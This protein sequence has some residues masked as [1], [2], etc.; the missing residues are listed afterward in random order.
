MLALKFFKRKKEYYIARLK[1][2]PHFDEKSTFL[3]MI[4]ALKPQVEAV[5]EEIANSGNDPYE[6]SKHIIRDN[7]YAAL[8]NHIKKRDE[9]EA[10]AMNKML[11]MLANRLKATVSKSELYNK[12]KEMNEVYMEMQEAIGEFNSDRN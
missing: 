10:K 4:K 12:G 2:D 11:M 8:M 7:M 5:Q 1:E 3:I 6:N 9:K